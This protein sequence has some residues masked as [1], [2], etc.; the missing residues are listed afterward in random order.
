MRI[1]PLLFAAIAAIPLSACAVVSAGVGVA[2]SVISTTVDVTGDVV[3]AAV[4]TVADD[5]EED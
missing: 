4:H 1:L 2:G 5:D 3:G